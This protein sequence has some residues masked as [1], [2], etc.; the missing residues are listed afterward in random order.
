MPWLV[1]AVAWPLPVVV[2]SEVSPLPSPSELLLS[3][4]SSVGLVLSV[5]VVVP[6]WPAHLALISSEVKAIESVATV[7][8]ASEL[9]L[10][11]GVAGSDEVDVAV[12]EVGGATVA[13]FPLPP[14]PAS[15]NSPATAMAGTNP[16]RNDLSMVHAVSS[17]SPKIMVGYGSQWLFVL[18]G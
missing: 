9:E 14:Q 12:G 10:V 8:A 4:L 11:L 5:G 1:I 7:L 6:D 15:S 17:R 13:A 2:L 18:S 3:V 16:E